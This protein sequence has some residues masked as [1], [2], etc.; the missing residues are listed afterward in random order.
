MNPLEAHQAV[1]KMLDAKI[2]SLESRLRRAEAVVQ[3][4]RIPHS[5]VLDVHVWKK[6]QAALQAYDLEGGEVS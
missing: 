2:K 3:A 4:A 6:L 1:N 5:L